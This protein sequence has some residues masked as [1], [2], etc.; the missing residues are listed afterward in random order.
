[1]R[2]P[3]LVFIVLSGCV[4]TPAPT[5]E[6]VPDLDPTAGLLLTQ[7]IRID[8]TRPAREPSIMVTPGGRL[9]VAGYVNSGQ[10]DVPGPPDQ[11]LFYPYLWTSRDNGTSWT[12]VNPGS[13]VA[14]AFGD[15]DVSLAAAAD[16]T[17]YFATMTF[18]PAFTN[19]IVSVAASRDDGASWRWTRL[20]AGPFEDRPWVRVAPDGTAHVVWN[21]G[22]GIFHVASKD[23]GA[24]WSSPRIVRAEGGDGGFD[25]G[26]VGELA[27]RVV[28]L[29]AN[30]A[31]FAS[32]ASDGVLVSTTGTQWEWRT[33][34]GKRSW[35]RGPAERD[36]PPD[37]TPRA[38]DPVAFD[39]SGNLYA[40]WG[41]GKELMLARSVD[42]GAS[43]TTVTIAKEPQ[44]NP[45]FP[46]LRGDRNADALGV[47]WFVR[48]GTTLDARVAVV[49][50]PTDGDAHV[51]AATAG[52]GLV[53]THGE[54]FEVAFNGGGELVS[55]VP[56][57]NGES[58]LPFLQYRR[59]G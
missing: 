4:A 10:R 52:Q 32:G 26:P 24:T 42:L 49:A 46:F 34:P 53:E 33:L 15:S 43:W 28:P 50:W 30:G 59:A 16:G 14:G 22:R 54:Y 2:A 20:A 56:T 21:N 9:F 47:S 58:R 5:K 48:N 25:V 57:P 17:L 1:M 44:G 12:R 35:P 39:A 36:P 40:A 11:T 27:I 31:L 29:M 8:A 3:L 51:K 23:G 7:P 41:E 55:A 19:N 13:P 18:T 6:V 38:W 45:Q 37:G